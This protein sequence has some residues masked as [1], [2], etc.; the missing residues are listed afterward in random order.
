M[1]AFGE[2][3]RK[4]INRPPNSFLA[5]TS[6]RVLID[7]YLSRIFGGKITI[8]S[9][10]V[11]GTKGKGSTCA[12]C[13]SILRSCGFKTGLFTSPHLVSP[14]ERIRINGKQI[15]EEYFV[16]KYEDL[17]RELNRC[18]LPV[19]PFFAFQTLMS[20]VV[21]QE[22]NVDC[23]VVEVGIGGKFDWTKIYEPT[24]AGITHLDFDHTET[25]GSTPFSIAWNKFGIFTKNSMNFAMQ[26]N[27][28]F[29]KSLDFISRYSGIK[30]ETVE[31][32]WNGKTGL[33]GPCAIKNSSFGVAITKELVK[34]LKGKQDFGVKIDEGV[35]NT[36]IAGRF[37][38]IRKNNIDWLLD[39]AHTVD[40]IEY[41]YQWYDSLP[42]N[43]GDDILI[44]STTKKRNPNKLIKPFLNK[45]WKKIFYIS[46]YNHTHQIN[47]NSCRIVSSLRS[48]IKEASAM[49]PKSILVTGSLHLVGDVMKEIGY[50]PY[51]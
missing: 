41:C 28:E 36:F 11:A 40:S 47:N 24:V 12:V 15:S 2:V 26:Q 33:T 17:I 50:T 34:K 23:A 14:T 21:F 51:L 13:E 29:Q 46:S 31:P 27:K 37:Q 10:V 42:M 16:A 20:G 1:D 3:V 39:S 18:K 6:K 7:T 35:E 9:I 44:F 5:H 4:M 19:L 48:G 30:Y 25:L 38:K 8:P 22:E 49:K 43:S 32:F 45:K